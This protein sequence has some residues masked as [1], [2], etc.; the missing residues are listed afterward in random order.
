MTMIVDDVVRLMMS[1]YFT[2]VV[3]MLLLFHEILGFFNG[4]FDVFQT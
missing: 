2:S 1:T 3:K 4:V